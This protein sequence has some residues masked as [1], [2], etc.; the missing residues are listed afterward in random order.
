LVWKNDSY[1]KTACDFVFS[2]AGDAGHVRRIKRQTDWLITVTLPFWIRDPQKVFASPSW[3]V[4]CPICGAGLV[5][6]EAKVPSFVTLTRRSTNDILRAILHWWYKGS[7]VLVCWSEITL[8]ISILSPSMLSSSSFS[9]PGLSLSTS[10]T[11]GSHSPLHPGEPAGEPPSRRLSSA[12][13][14]LPLRSSR[15]RCAVIVPGVLEWAGYTAGEVRQRPQTRRT[16]HHCLKD[17]VF[18]KNT[19]L[20]FWDGIRYTCNNYKLSFCF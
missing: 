12:S 10:S 8:S 14:L 3:S 18:N 9:V 2:S 20:P 16:L 1:G 6:I 11:D 19:M 15:D 17:H 7:I 13:W 4:K 5:T